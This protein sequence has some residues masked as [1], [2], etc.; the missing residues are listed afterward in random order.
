MPKNN[1]DKHP[2]A[3]YTAESDVTRSSFKLIK[4]VISNTSIIKKI[5]KTIQAAQSFVKSIIR[6][7]TKSAY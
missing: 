1:N 5:H 7:V 2:N 6:P 4:K 3:I